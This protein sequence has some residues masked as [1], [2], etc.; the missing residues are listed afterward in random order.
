MVLPRGDQ[1]RS[2]ISLLLAGTVLAASTAARAAEE[3]KFGKAPA[4]VVP[5]VIPAVSDKA[6]DRP[7]ALLL[8]DQQ[9][10][11]EPGKI[12]TYAELAFKIQTSEGLAAGNLS[13][14]WNPAFDTA[15]V[16]RLE[17]RRGDQVIDVLKSGQTFTTM[18]R[19][20]KLE[21]ATLD[22]MLTAN[23]QPEG[24]QEGDV[25]VLATT[26]EHADPVLKGHVETMFAPWG[27]AQIGLAHARLAWPS[28]LDVKI[29][30]AGDLPAGQQ[31]A[32]DGK[33]VV[34]FSM[35][36]AEPVISP[37]GAPL[38]FKIGRIG[39]ATDFRSWADAAKLLAPLFRDAAVIPASGPLRDEVEKIRKTSA[40]PKVRAEQ[41][42]QLVEQRIRYV[43]LAMG[44]GGLVPATAET[45]WSRRF[46]DCKAK[47]AL[48]LGILH[49]FGIAA[50]PVTVNA[51]AG[52][53]V[54]EWLPMIT[55]F[56]HVLVRAHI[57]GK[58]Y[59]LDGTRSGDT[60]LDSIEV[61][62]FGWGLPL[63][64]NA[65]LVHLVPRPRELPDHERHLDVDASDGVYAPAAIS[66]TEIYRGDSAVDLNTR[67]AALSTAQRD[68]L[69]QRNANDYFDG[70]QVG[71]SSL[72]FDKVKREY[73]ILIKGTAK[74]NWNNSWFDVPT[75]SIA[76][77]PD[78]QRPAGPLHDV[79]IEVSH[80]RFARD[81]VS[82]KL[83][84][85]FAAQQKVDPAVHETLAG[86]EYA[87]TETVSGDTLTVES[88]ERSLVPE[89]SY[90]EAVAAA[91]RLKALAQN[92]VYLSNNVS[93]RVSEKDLAALKD[94]TPGS[95]QEFVDR[96]NLFLDRGKYDE[97]IADF[98]AALKLEPENKWALADRGVA[99]AWKQQF[100]EAEKDLTA[101]AARDPDNVVI[102]RGQGLLAEFRS[103]CAKALELY[104]RSLA[105]DPKSNFTIGHRA[106]CEARLS[107]YDSALADSAQA[108]KTDPSWMD[109]RMLRA[110]IFMQQGKHD[111]VAA[112]AE[113]L[114]REN[115]KS[116]YA[117]VGAARTYA[118]LGKREL[119][120]Q[121]LD[122]A[123]A[124]QPQ[125]YI[126][127]NRSQIRPRS[128]VSA[129]MADL[130][131]ALKLEPDSEDA[132]TEKARLL[133][134]RG[135]YKAALA[136]LDRLKP[137]PNN[138]YG[139]MQRGIA[140]YRAGR[141]TEAQKIFADL[142]SQAKM[143]AELNNLCWS[144]ATAGVAL[145]SALQD[146][147]DA[148]K[149]SP[150]V[151]GFIDSLGMALLKLGRLDEA[152]D[153][154]NR[155]IAKDSG[156]AS[157]MG[158]AFVYLRKGDRPH[159]EADAAAARKLEANI[160]D[161]FAEYG[162]NFDQG[163]TKTVAAKGTAADK[164]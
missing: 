72:Q 76:F 70:F 10:L 129:R 106:T 112:E 24:L 154:Y 121:A 81:I 140:L 31:S 138:R 91:A 67:Y 143:A 19:E 99:Y 20:S 43:A 118:A 141:T 38:R 136:I 119:A 130:E 35:R 78:F 159:A 80:P 113:A 2:V 28:T 96:G 26:I 59:W 137:D 98:T 6:K 66:L 32:R 148:L 88:S 145:E 57:S 115:P 62:D 84:P 47:T 45:T 17:I 52:D 144:K 135:D 39:E 161:R 102:T 128:D 71:S 42:L 89:V 164:H 41:A 50:E 90:K 108:L 155:A 133:G 40:D 132:L 9:V 134:D 58:D 97:A 101:A 162:L 77:T 92:N 142:R 163:S 55:A 61:P 46:G 150:D 34:D 74:L 104:A 160:D 139:E 85:G 87:R 22:G 75:S 23:I 54:V 153:A 27:S 83:P 94:A 109:L 11:L 100:N 65:Q 117:W 124:V 4:W 53:A 12:D 151:G 82:F 49:E 44:E 37:K 107:Q 103:D 7:I 86:V 114:T 125:A 126:Y 157:L 29:K 16:N 63:V 64:D 158:R 127:V 122:R 3:L 131:A 93:Y 21:L 111:L 110:N 95:A 146:C 5:Q 30:Q 8:H 147:R 120:M 51:F 1:M 36:N 116:D 69:L 123:I 15:T 105:K 152:L 13:I 73:A 56:N 79:P 33:K 48:L 25:I 156:A 14:A 60:S 18:R 149:L 68:E